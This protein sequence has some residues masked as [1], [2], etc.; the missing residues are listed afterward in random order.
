MI[1]NNVQDKR[2]FNKKIG[3]QL[4]NLT[5]FTYKFKGEMI[6]VSD[7]ICDV[8]DSSHTLDQTN[9]KSYK[10]FNKV[11]FW[12]I[13]LKTQQLVELFMFKAEMIFVSNAI[14]D[15]DDGRMHFTLQHTIQD[16]RF[17]NQH[18]R[19]TIDFEKNGIK[20]HNLAN[21]NFKFKAGMIFVLD[22]IRDVDY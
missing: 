17:N 13:W 20:L 18:S 14:C 5:N 3:V 4:Y 6:F 7:A 9:N 1:N 16:P 11:F 8:D 22:A 21:F 12:K 2:N 19:W 15:V 10:Q